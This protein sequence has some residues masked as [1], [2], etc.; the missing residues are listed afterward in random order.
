MLCN[1]SKKKHAF[2]TCYGLI[3]QPLLEQLAA[4]FGGN[5]QGILSLLVQSPKSDAE[6]LHEAMQ[7][8]YGWLSLVS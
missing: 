3:F 2:Q 6:Q 7:V 4:E 1:F 5:S 8:Q